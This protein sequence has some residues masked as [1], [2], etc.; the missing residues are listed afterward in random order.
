MLLSNMG[1]TGLKT[2]QR[3][4]LNQLIIAKLKN[5]EMELYKRS[6]LGK[7]VQAAAKNMAKIF[8]QTIE[9][10]NISMLF[11]L[12]RQAI[13]CD[14]ACY[15]END[16]RTAAKAALN[17]AAHFFQQTSTIEGAQKYL[18]SQNG[19]IL[20]EKIPPSDLV[21]N[22]VR[23]Q[24]TQLTQMINATSSPALKMLR[25]HRKESLDL[26]RKEYVKNFEAGLGKT[27]Q[28]QRGMGRT[29]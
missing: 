9:E 29:P 8:R 18:L 15:G 10:K 28:R 4:I 19:G 17:Q 11:E 24:K 20:P 13:E 23:N 3:L 12:E 22:F 6:E 7:E 26:I 21:L 27:P 25:M 14:I 5:A 1:K 16:K 2:E